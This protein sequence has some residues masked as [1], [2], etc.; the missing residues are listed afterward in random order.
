MRLVKRRRAA[1]SSSCGLFVAPMTRTRAADEVPTPSNCTRN[2]VFSRLLASCSD[3]ERAPRIESTSSMKMTAGCSSVATANKAR[4]SFSPCPCHFEVRE[5]A[6]IEKNVQL[7]SVA[8]AFA[9]KV[10]PVPGGP[11]NKSPLGGERMPVKRS[12]R[13]AGRITISSSVFLATERPAISSQH[14]EGLRSSTSFIIAACISGSTPLMGGS[15]G[16]FVGVVPVAPAACV[17]DCRGTWNGPV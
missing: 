3:S 13:D 5:E 11:N 2:S 16:A 6:E 7:A 17:G 4:T 10:L 14:T 8:T 1:S 15:A 9:S 12:G